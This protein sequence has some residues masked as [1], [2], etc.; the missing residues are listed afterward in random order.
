MSI[1]INANHS[2]TFSLSFNYYIA[3][4]INN[5]GWNMRKKNKKRKRTSKRNKMRTNKR[6]KE[7][8]EMEDKLLGQNQ[9]WNHLWLYVISLNE[10]FFFYNTCIH[11]INRN[12]NVKVSSHSDCSRKGRVSSIHKTI[13]SVC[14]A[15]CAKQ[16]ATL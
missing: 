9:Q 2:I 10:F 3:I 14:Q 11:F 8:Q 15:L 13:S 16:W 5:V 1:S 6:W 12:Y 4:H 7:E